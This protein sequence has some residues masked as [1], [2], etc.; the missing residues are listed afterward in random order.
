MSKLVEQAYCHKLGVRKEFVDPNP[1]AQA[2]ATTLLVARTKFYVV[3]HRSILS[4]SPLPKE[5]AAIVTGNH[6]RKADSFKGLQHAINTARR[7]ITP[8]VKL[9]LIK[10]GAIESMAYL[11][12]IGAQTEALGEY[13]PINAFVLRHTGAVGIL[14]DNPGLSFVRTVDKGLKD[15]RLMAIYLQPTRNDD[16]I[17]RNLQPG[18]AYFAKRHP[19]VPVFPVA[20]SGPPEEADRAIFMEPFTYAQKVAEYGRE[21]SEGELTIMIADSIVPGLP[22]RSQIDWATRWSEELLRLN[23][24]KK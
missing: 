21:I 23:S 10:E 4:G 2:A 24:Q 13:N 20:F 6:Q 11:E 3:T 22:E 7:L 18:A 9:S 17:L 1:K 12:S 16:C 15:Q 14:R 19:D 8:V 5:G